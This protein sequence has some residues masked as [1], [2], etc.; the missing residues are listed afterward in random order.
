MIRV[1][2]LN[3]AKI[4]VVAA[5][6]LHIL[7]VNS[8]VNGPQNYAVRAAGPCDVSGNGTDTP[9]GFLRRSGLQGVLNLP[10][11]LRRRSI[12]GREGRQKQ[13][14]RSQETEAKSQ[15]IPA[16]EAAG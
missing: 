3:V 14:E 11:Q 1:E 9:K 8:S 13:E 16:F 12:E 5:G 6:N 15:S 4:Q 2:C 7:P 10:F